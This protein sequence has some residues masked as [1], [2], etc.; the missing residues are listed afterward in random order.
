VSYRVLDHTADTGVEVVAASRD[1]LFAE[2]LRA[3]TD[4]V[5][6]VGR[7]GE[8]VRRRLAVSAETLPDLLA[9][10]LEELLYRFETEGLLF[11]RA[12]VAIAEEPGGLALTAEV[13]GEEYDAARHPLKILVKA[14]THYL[15]EA[16]SAPGGGWR[17][18]VIFDI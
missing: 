5:T 17:A 9:V 4:T 3:F 16:G 8:G 18:R 2:A 10:W 12:E 13:E 15:L 7:V 6:E 11:S 14:V 1:A